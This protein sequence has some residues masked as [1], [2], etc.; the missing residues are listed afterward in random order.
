MTRGDVQMLNVGAVLGVM[1]GLTTVVESD[2]R[3][4]GFGVTTAG[5]LGG[6]AL[7]DRYWVRKVDHSASDASQ[8]YLGMLAGGLIGAGVLVLAEADEPTAVLGT[9]TGT[10]LAGAILGQKMAAPAPASGSRTGLKPS[11]QRFGSRVSLDPTAIAMAAS[12]VPGRHP[13]LRVTF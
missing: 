12:K 10:M 13:L 2:N 6:L 4:V 9:L 1:T 11:I 3:R 5:M 8:V 7:A